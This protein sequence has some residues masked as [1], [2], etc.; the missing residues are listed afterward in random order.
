MKKANEKRG[1][2]VLRGMA[3]LTRRAA[4]NGTRSCELF[5]YQPKV[6][7]NMA[8][9]LQVMKEGENKTV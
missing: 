8:A 9:R 4:Q 3:S 6:P 7:A 1:N 5:I 2:P